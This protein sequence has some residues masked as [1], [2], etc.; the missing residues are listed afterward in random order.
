[1]ALT[2]DQQN[3]IEFLKAEEFERHKS[4]RETLVR[5]AKIDIIKMARETLIENARNKPVSD[6]EVTAEDIITFAKSLET[7]LELPE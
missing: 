5:Q 1:M 2:E 3:R 7:Y 4:H 6:R